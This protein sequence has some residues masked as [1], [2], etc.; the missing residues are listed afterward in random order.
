MLFIILLYLPGF[1]NNGNIVNSYP[2]GIKKETPTSN[3]IIPDKSAVA[4]NK[5]YNFS[6]YPKKYQT[7]TF[8]KTD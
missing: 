3:L 8:H 5:D 4:T 6:I 7:S 2:E 1:G